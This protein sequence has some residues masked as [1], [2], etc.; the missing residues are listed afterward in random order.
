M[1]S[2]TKVPDARPK[3][4]KRPNSILS[5]A[6][7]PFIFYLHFAIVYLL[8]LLFWCRLFFQDYFPSQEWQL[9]RISLL[10]GLLFWSIPIAI[11]FAGIVARVKFRTWAAYVIVDLIISLLAFS[12][13]GAIHFVLFG[14]IIGGKY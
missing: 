14:R 2:D 9:G 1:P 13:I 4:P 5:P 7:V 11:A 10:Q 8:I 12:W 6:W 3:P